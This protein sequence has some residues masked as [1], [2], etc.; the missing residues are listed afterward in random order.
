MIWGPL[1]F[2]RLCMQSLCSKGLSP[3]LCK[4]EL[5][6]QRIFTYWKFYFLSG[7]PPAAGK[8]GG[9]SGARGQLLTPVP[10]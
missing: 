4:N 6:P 2:D 5:T 7:N 9:C 10:H 3:K 8:Q 1:G